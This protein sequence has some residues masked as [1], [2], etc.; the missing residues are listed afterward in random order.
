MVSGLLCLIAGFSALR[1]G[2]A[3]AF[4]ALFIGGMLIWPVSLG[5]ARFAFSAAPVLRGDPIDTLGLES[6]FVLFAGILVAYGVL[7]VAP[8]LAL[9]VVAVTI[10]ARYAIFR[11][12]YAERLYWVRGA[13][14]AVVGSLSV[15]TVDLPPQTLAFVVGTTEV[16]FSIALFVRWQR[17]Q[18]SSLRAS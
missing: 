16:G 8:V 12:L 10:G 1:W 14:I 17:R 7:R 15:F 4:T 11:T 2:E 9:P 13:A 18:S 6:T 3:S 5:V